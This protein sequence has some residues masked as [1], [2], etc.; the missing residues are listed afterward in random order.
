MYAIVGPPTAYNLFFK[1]KFH[2]VVPP[3]AQANSSTMKIFELWKALSEDER[4]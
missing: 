3:G 1:A 2:S 4:K